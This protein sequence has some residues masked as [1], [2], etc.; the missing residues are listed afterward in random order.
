MNKYKVKTVTEDSNTYHFIARG[1]SKDFTDEEVAAYM[2]ELH[3]KEVQKQFR[4]EGE[5]R[6]IFSQDL[7]FGLKHCC[8]KYGVSR[9]QLMA[10]ARRL[11]PQMNIEKIVGLDE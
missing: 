9:E 1:K 8:L 4:V 2:S 7:R 5:L 6:K 11:F 10:E 3:P